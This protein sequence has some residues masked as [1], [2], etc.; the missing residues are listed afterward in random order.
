MA[1]TTVANTIGRVRRQLDSTG[2]HEINRL[3]EPLDAVEEDITVE[4]ATNAI[5]AGAVLNVD[6]ELMRVISYNSGTKTASVVRGYLDSDAAT[7]ADDAEVLVNPRFNNL[8]IFDAMIDE[9]GTWGPALFRVVSDEFEV[10]GVSGVLELP[11][12]WIT[13]Y[14]LLDVR[15]Q[16]TAQF[17]NPESWP[18]V[19]HRL[20]RG[21]V[22]DWTEGAATSGMQLR[23]VDDVP[24]TTLYVLAA[25]PYDMSTLTITDDLVDDAG[26]TTSL[27]ELLVAGTKLRLMLD[28]EHGRSARMAQD[29]SRRAEETPVGAMQSPLQFQ[30]AAYQMKRGAEVARLRSQYPLWMS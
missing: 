9:V 8:D 27:I 11:I 28:S 25:L 21:P 17:G 13:M 5:V 29:D 14:H 18:R 19:A 16:S 22:G 15:R 7:H 20:I 6:L 26:L 4:W 10:D 1:R 2:R 23:I 3:A 12:G 24:S 30:M